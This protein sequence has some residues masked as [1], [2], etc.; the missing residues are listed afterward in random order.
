M[1]PTKLEPGE[2]SV[3]Y[4]SEVTGLLARP[5]FLGY[6]TTRTLS[7]RLLTC[8]DPACT[9]TPAEVVKVQAVAYR[10]AVP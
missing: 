9:Q 1:S 7:S 3:L 4:K 8:C 2:M 5:F 6:P 10:I